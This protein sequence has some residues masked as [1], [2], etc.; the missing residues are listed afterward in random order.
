MSTQK[1][2]SFPQTRWLRAMLTAG[3]RQLARDDSAHQ[4]I[5]R[6]YLV[7]RAALGVSLVV[8]Q[9]V[10][11]WLLHRAPIEPLVISVAYVGLALLWW[12]WSGRTPS[13][14]SRLSAFQWWATIGID[15]LAFGCLHALDG[16]GVLNYGALLVLPV[17]MAGVLAD[18]GPAG[19]TA[20]A[21]AILL[22]GTA[23]QRALSGG[24]AETA[25]L[26]SQAGMAGVG[27]FV[28]ALVAGQMGNRLTSGEMAARGSMA[29]AR[30]QVELNRLVL[31]EM[32]DG[33]LVVDEQGRVRAAN[34]AAR[35]LLSD[36]GSC[37][38]APF[39][40]SERPQWRPLLEAVLSGYATQRW[41]SAGL[42]V[43]LS[44]ATGGLP[45]QLRVRAKF[46]RGTPLR[47]VGDLT[48]A[49]Q[50]KLVVL[51]A[52][53]LRKVLKR[54][55]E[56]RLVAMGRISA[57]VAHEIRNPLAAISQAN[58]LLQE[59]VLRP[60]QQRLVRIV[61][62]N[63][64]RLKRIVNDV[65]EAAPGGSMPIR[66]IDASAEIG[67]IVAEWAHTEGLIPGAA[68]PLALE[69]P[70]YPLHVAFDPDHLRRVLTNL[71]ENGLR[72]ASGQPGAVQVRLEPVD[73]TLARLSVASDGQPI[74]PEVE[75]HLFEPFHSTRSR[76]TGLGLYICRELCERHQARI[77]FQ[78]VTAARH[79]NVF[80]V[81]MQADP[82]VQPSTLSA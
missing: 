25:S 55:K 68:C 63:V 67:A 71:L 38:D 13:T 26:L 76:G 58:A 73:G 79:C 22:V 28:I 16:Q 46:T 75:Q 40:L 81:T 36:D 37:P 29:L 45:Q 39:Q 23:F 49:I 33:V 20:A 8:A 30:Q 15:L 10:L 17:L 53:D 1:S 52:E 24:G 21:V 32:N 5:F 6:T 9:S 27:M 42:D 4:R 48:D 3:E 80:T 56:E 18:R 74:P 50:A 34:P 14:V 51:F 77:D 82:M 65:M 61:S 7:V 64:E 72:H 66:W 47:A 11:G 44:S 12:G 69:L 60:D 62:D 43:T 35:Q 78:W 31:D 54:Q 70:G 59:D 57:G 41:P 2:A 19:A